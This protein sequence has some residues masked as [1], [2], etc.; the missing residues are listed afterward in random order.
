MGVQK[1]PNDNKRVSPHG[2]GVACLCQLAQLLKAK[3]GA[4]EERRAVVRHRVVEVH[5]N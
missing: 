4:G 3:A 1:T 2:V 5:Q